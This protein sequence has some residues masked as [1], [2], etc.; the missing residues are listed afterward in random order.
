MNLFDMSLTW[1]FFSMIA[2]FA[3]ILVGVISILNRGTFM[4]VVGVELGV[5][6]AWLIGM[7]GYAI[8]AYFVRHTRRP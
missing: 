4:E 8:L 1:K 2:L 3:F 6:I 5:I 7:V